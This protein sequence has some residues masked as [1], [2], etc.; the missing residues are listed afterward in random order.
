[1]GGPQLPR[2]H[3]R[4]RRSPPLERARRSGRAPP[5]RRRSA[6]PSA[7]ERR[8][9]GR[10]SRRR[11]PPRA[12]ARG[13]SLAGL[14]GRSPG[15]RPRSP[16]RAADPPTSARSRARRTLRDPDAPLR[17]RRKRALT[18]GRDRRCRAARADGGDRPLGRG[19]DARRVGRA[20]ANSTGAGRCV[21]DQPL[22]RIAGQRVAAGA[23]HRP[24][25]SDADPSSE[26]LLR[27]HRDGGRRERRRRPLA[28]SAAAK[29]G[30][31]LRHRRFRERHVVVR[32]PSGPSR[33][34]P[35]D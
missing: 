28:P 33:R 1:M 16:L 35:E 13:A 23:H 19:P 6:E 27:D 4:G 34:L 9:A 25:R 5:G 24:P 26:S 18:R 3:E 32:L 14:A 12:Q 30:M 2:R 22:R 7:F 29:R 17:P 21:R 31:P 15:E 11:D 10:A 20:S 8:A